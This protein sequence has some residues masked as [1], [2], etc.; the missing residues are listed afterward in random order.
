MSQISRFERVW[1]GSRYVLAGIFLA[2]GTVAPSPSVLGAQTGSDDG[3]PQIQAS[4]IC[5]GPHGDP[6]TACPV[7]PLADVWDVL[8]TP[9]TAN[10]YLLDVPKPA[11]HLQLDLT[12][13]P[14]DYDLYLFTPDDASFESV[15]EGLAPESISASLGVAGPHLIY[16]AVDP[17]REPAPDAAYRLHIQLED[18]AGVAGVTAPVDQ[19]TNDAGAPVPA[20]ATP[21]PPTAT[22]VPPTATPVPPTATPAPTVLYKADFSG[23]IRDWQIVEPTAVWTNSGGVLSPSL[24]HDFTSTILAPYRPTS[25]DYAI[26][27]EAQS[28]GGNTWYLIARYDS[29]RFMAA[30]L[31]LFAGIAEIQDN[32]SGLGCGRDASAKMSFD[33][34]WHTYRFELQG[35]DY[36]LYVDGVLTVHWNDAT[37]LG[38]GRAGVF[39]GPNTRVNVR[40][41][42]ILSL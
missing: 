6:D 36:R 2:L 22:P 3:L 10:V 13:L 24:N 35:S 7:P 23:S 5:A 12:E 16:V 20:T 41:F 11:M 14:A 27:A 34:N 18:G 21:V 25:A 19:T 32:P 17:A 28:L 15:H 37:V 31:C 29:A 42:R 26:E 4:D 40:A 30:G 9:G 38:P 8:E 33:A 39:A 1:K